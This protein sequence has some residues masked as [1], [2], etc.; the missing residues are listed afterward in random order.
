M[1]NNTHIFNLKVQKIEQI[2]LFELTWGQKQ[3]LATQINYPTN[4]TK[5][6]QDWRRAYLNFYQSENLRGRAIEDENVVLCVDWHAELVK[7]ETKLIYEFNTWLR[8]VE[9]FEIRAQISRGSEESQDENL[10]VNQ[11]VNQTIQIFLTCS[12][13]ELDRFPW[14]AWEIGTEFTNNRTIQIIRAPL[15]I[16]S[17]ATL[18]PLR[19]NN[20]KTRILAILGD[21]TGQNFKA[22]EEALKELKKIVDVEFT[23][24]Q[25]QETPSQVRKNIIDAIANEKGWDLLFFAGHSNETEIT[26]GELGIAPGVSIFINEIATQLNAAKK[27]GLKVAIFNS[28]SGLN[29]ADS[30][31]DLGFNQVVVMREPIH[32]SVAQEFLVRFLHS[33][34][35][36]LD[37]YESLTKARQFLR[38][39]KSHTY[40]S[41]YLVPSLFCHPGA[42]LFRIPVVGWKQHFQRSLPNYYEAAIITATLLLSLLTPVQEILLDVR[43]FTQA[44]YRNFVPI[45]NEEAPPVALVEID[46]KSIARRKL[47]PNQLSPISRVYLAEL[48]EQVRKLNASVVTLD[49]VVDTPQKELEGDK[50]L[51]TAVTRAVNQNAWIIFTTNLDKNTNQESDINQANGIRDRNWTVQGYN[52]AHPYF[53]ELPDA[54]QGC[55]QIC[56][57]SYLMALVHTAKQEITDLPQPKTSG[58]V[59]LRTQLLDTIAKERSQKGKLQKLSQWQPPLGLQPIV[60]YSIPPKQIYT[61]IPAWKLL[62]NPDINQFPLI[63]QQVV[64]I[65]VGDDERLGMVS[66][67]PDRLPTPLAMNYWTKQPWLTGGES[68]AYMTHHFL[69]QR[70]VTPIPDFWMVGVALILGKIAA[71]LLAQKSPLNP[72]LRLKI[73]ISACSFVIL[74][75]LAALQIYISAAI[76]LPWFLPSSAF[77]AYIIPAIRSKKHA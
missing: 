50:K 38:N 23:G 10:K 47:P 45:P 3:R 58:K 53:V 14:E 31:I 66:G 36:H 22:E 33:L 76:L 4:L 52:D 2:C 12:P 55:R 24:W 75:L 51:G 17:E 41:S 5:I 1:K 19:Q 34:G 13:I 30:L 74:Y 27:R 8:S 64:L 48:M 16:T 59:D 65:A 62:E 20:R 28:C 77:L 44:A 29:I 39:Q 25:P 7:T 9:L 43:L 72:K 73:L 11:T 26:G 56:P 40:P 67:Q 37:L 57:I 32:N 68:L 15:Q 70:L 71:I 42:E 49:F 18:S 21:E 54:N 63:S 69:T 6:Y 61:K 46:T 60:D 35:E